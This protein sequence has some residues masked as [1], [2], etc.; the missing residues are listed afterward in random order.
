MKLPCQ[1]SRILSPAWLAVIGPG[2][3][4]CE[5]N[6]TASAYHR[7]ELSPLA[8][9]NV[10]VGLFTFGVMVPMVSHVLLVVSPGPLLNTVVVAGNVVL[11]TPM[12]V[13]LTTILAV[14]P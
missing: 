4:G 9:V 13:L 8:Q 3:G 1:F 2:L 14:S 11:D 12:T 7:S 6:R 5:M 10:I